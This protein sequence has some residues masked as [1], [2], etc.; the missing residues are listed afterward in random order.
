[1][2]ASIYRSPLFTTFHSQLWRSLEHFEQNFAV[3]VILLL[4]ASVK[5]WERH[6][7]SKSVSCLPR[8]LWE[9]S[10]SLAAKYATVVTSWSPTLRVCRLVQGRRCAESLLEPLFGK[11][12][13]S[14]WDPNSGRRKRSTKT[15]LSSTAGHKTKTLS[16]K[17]SKCSSELEGTLESGDTFLWVCHYEKHLFHDA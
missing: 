11:M 16:W 12:K 8:L 15:A 10:G 17:T 14:C 7:A 6:I 2:I 5:Y 4:T 1:M 9:T 13:A 3:Q